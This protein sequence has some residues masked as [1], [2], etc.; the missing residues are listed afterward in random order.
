[1]WSLLNRDLLIPFHM[2]TPIAPALDKCDSFLLQADEFKQKD[3]FILM[4]VLRKLYLHLTRPVNLPDRLKGEVFDRSSLGE[5]TSK[6]HIATANSFDIILLNFFGDFDLAADV[7]I[8]AGD[9]YAKNVPADHIIMMETFHRGLSLYAM[10]LKT[11]Q[12]KYTKPAKK[13]LSTMKSW[14]QSGNPNVDQYCAFLS[15]EQAVI[16][17]DH[18]KADSMYKETISIAAKSGY[19]HVAA[20]CNERY[21]SY[22]ARHDVGKEDVVLPT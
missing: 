9:S 19:L 5:L 4:K 20:L 15:A 7:A 8:E 6:V 3:Q 10:A 21:A 2:G 1:M 12:K 17:K 18:A 22:L 11:K 13:I 16:D 14:V